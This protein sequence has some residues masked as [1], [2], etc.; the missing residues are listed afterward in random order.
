MET[1]VKE[2]NDLKLAVK[3]RDEAIR[4]SQALIK[5]LELAIETSNGKV[6]SV[7]KQL[8][9]ANKQLQNLMKDL[10]L[11]LKIN[12]NLIERAG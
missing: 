3:Q 8:T 4:Q 5:V 1:I 7:T 12:E 9:E 2:F 10:N 6:G 11:I